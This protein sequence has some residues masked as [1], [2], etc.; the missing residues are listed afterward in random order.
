MKVVVAALR[1]EGREVFDFEA[2]RL[3]QVVIVGDDVGILLSPGAGR[4]KREKEQK[5]WEKAI[6]HEISLQLVCNREIRLN[7]SCINCK[8]FATP[9]LP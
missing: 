2:A 9:F 8:W 1:A 3:L 7:Q 5:G 6:A 4:K